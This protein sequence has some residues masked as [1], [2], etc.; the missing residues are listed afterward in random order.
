MNP[1]KKAFL[2]DVLKVTPKT[3]LFGIGDDAVQAT[4][5][6]KQ[7]RKEE[8]ALL[9]QITTLDEFSGSDAEAEKQAAV[10]EAEVKSA[11]AHTESA[12][13][14][15]PKDVKA[16]VE[17]AL[18]ML[19][20]TKVKLDTAVPVTKARQQFNKTANHTRLLLEKLKMTSTSGKAVETDVAYTKG[21]NVELNKKRATADDFNE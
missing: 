2:L 20:A 21:A 18:K 12:K 17:E 11:L 4:T 9:A 14:G 1:T 10:F 19:Q 6:F 15:D 3:K 16:K 7:Y 13:K 8:E 5:A